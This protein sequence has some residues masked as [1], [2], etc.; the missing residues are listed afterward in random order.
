MSAL[1]DRERA[2]LLRVHHT[3]CGDPGNCDCGELRRRLADGVR[4]RLPGFSDTDLA[5]VLLALAVE[6][7]PMTFTLS[8]V[9]LGG[10]IARCAAELGELELDTGP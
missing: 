9:A 8:G 4:R 5:R 3:P 7:A 2:A 6:S 1:T 10:L